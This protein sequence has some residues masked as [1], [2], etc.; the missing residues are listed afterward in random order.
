MIEVISKGVGS[1]EIESVQSSELIETPDRYLIDLD[2][3][4][5]KVLAGTEE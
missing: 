5:S 3:R 2:M 4:P 1:G